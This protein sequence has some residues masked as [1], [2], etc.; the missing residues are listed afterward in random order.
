VRILYTF[1]KENG[2]WIVTCPSDKSIP[3]IT[4]NSLIEAIN[5]FLAIHENIK[6]FDL[7]IPSSPK[8]AP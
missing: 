3:K 5:K 8:T 1:Q 2:H 6:Y 7:I 4:Y